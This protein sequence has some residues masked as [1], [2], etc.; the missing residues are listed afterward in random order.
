MTTDGVNWTKLLDTGA[1]RG[2]PANC[3]FDWISQPSDPAL[4]VSFAGRSIVRVRGF[5]PQA[6]R[7]SASSRAVAAPERRAVRPPAAQ[8]SR[9][10]TRDGG[11]GT[12]QAMPDERVLVTFDDGRTL[13]VDADQLQPQ[14]D[15]TYLV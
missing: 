1:I 14:A 11:V 10:R 7:E 13:V 6:A 15:G 3:Y 2:R 12:T 5:A 9:I 4:Y 8:Q